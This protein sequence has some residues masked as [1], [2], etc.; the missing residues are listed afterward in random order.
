MLR[1]PRAIGVR[2][3]LLWLGGAR[4]VLVVGAGLRGVSLLCLERL[5]VGF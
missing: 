3:L 5:G 1:F 4:G 2:F